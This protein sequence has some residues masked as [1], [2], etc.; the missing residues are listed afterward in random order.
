MRGAHDTSQ[1]G[2]GEISDDSMCSAVC[3]D[4]KE[5]YTLPKGPFPGMKS[6]ERVMFLLAQKGTRNRTSRSHTI[7]WTSEAV[8]NYAAVTETGIPAAKVKYSKYSTLQCSYYF[9]NI[10]LILL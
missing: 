1:T 9:N 10:N 8:R 3:A 6:L 2:E 7:A 4:G 5:K